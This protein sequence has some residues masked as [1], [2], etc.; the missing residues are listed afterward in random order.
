MDQSYPQLTVSLVPDDVLLEIFVFYLDLD[1]KFYDEDAWC[2]LAHVCQRWRYLVFASPGHLRLRLYCTDTRPVKRMLDIWPELPIVIRGFWRASRLQDVTHTLAALKQR[3]RVSKISI[4]K[5]PMSLFKNIAT[6]KQ[7]PVLTNLEL[8]SEE[9]NENV[10]VLPGSF[11][12]G[13]APLLHELTL[14]GIPFPTVPKLLSSTSGLLDLYLWD[15]PPISGYISPEEIV[16][17]LSTLT[18]LKSFSL[19]FQYSPEADQATRHPPLTYTILPAL[20]RLEFRGESEY[21]ED[22]VSQI[23]AL[24]LETTRIFFFNQPI[25]DI[26]RLRHFIGRIETFK[27]AH[28]ANV[29]FSN[30]LF[31][32]EV[33]VKLVLQSGTDDSDH[34]AL[35]LA[36]YYSTSDLNLSL[37]ARL[38]CSA[39][40]PLSTFEH[41]CICNDKYW[42]DGLENDQVLEFFHPF[43]SVKDLVLSTMMARLVAPAIGR[44]T[45]DSATEVLPA[46]QN[47]FLEELQ[48]LGPVQQAIARFTA[49]RQPSDHPVAVHHREK[50]SC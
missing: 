9:E 2:T 20:I 14:S 46:L 17:S 41:L 30:D 32:G 49:V 48:S 45:A 40:P 47:I 25:F 26:P 16:A 21:L 12:E 37:L 33:Y 39:L 38:Y 35:E 43:T 15:I 10:P 36:L 42:R 31:L 29:I 13:S 6:M 44:L 3:H 28:R 5:I 11:L 7:L 8:S 24:L 18:R 34:R 22:L 19:G 4:E 50:V 23:D 1:S 27:S